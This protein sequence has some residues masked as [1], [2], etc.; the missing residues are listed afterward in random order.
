MARANAPISFGEENRTNWMCD[1]CG[2]TMHAYIRR[3]FLLCR[4]TAHQM[5][6][7]SLFQTL[8]CGQNRSRFVPHSNSFDRQRRQERA[9]T[10][11]TR[12]GIGRSSQMTVCSRG[13]K[14][15]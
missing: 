2:S 4:V 11:Q 8:S 3:R 7:S 9:R 15:R 14:T 13:Q 10:R 6:E 1:H 5:S 12:R